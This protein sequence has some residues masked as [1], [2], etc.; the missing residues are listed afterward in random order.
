MKSFCDWQ[1]ERTSAR[2][3]FTTQQNYEDFALTLVRTVALFGRTIRSHTT[4]TNLGRSTT[5]GVG[6]VP[7]RW[8]P[9]PF[10]P[11]TRDEELVWINAPLNWRDGGGYRAA[12]QRIHCARCLAVDRRTLS[13]A[14]SRRDRAVDP[15]AAPSRAR[16]RHR[17]MQLR[18]R[19]LPDLG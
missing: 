18:A 9:H 8:F 4:L 12:R 15:A 19:L 2:V 3:T 5:P 16:H 10:Y 1:I 6:F 17:D 7:M 11:Q 14:R 13:A